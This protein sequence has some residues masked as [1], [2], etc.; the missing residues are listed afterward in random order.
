L[1]P[2][3]N[4]LPENKVWSVMERLNTLNACHFFMAC[5]PD[6]PKESYAIDFSTLDC[7]D[8]VPLMRMRCGLSG[9]EI[10]RP[11]WSMTLN[12]AQ[13]PFVQ[14]ID[15]RRTIRELAACVA[16][17]KDTSRGS[18]ADFEKFGR[19]LFQALWRLDFLAMALHASDD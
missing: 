4:A 6:R 15:G 2:A 14:H 10:L 19:K 7:L 8:Y 9:T 16:Q 18:A 5:P 3:V 12:A 11:G 1:Y 13:L 17:S